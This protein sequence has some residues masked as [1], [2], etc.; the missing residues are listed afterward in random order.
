M[1]MSNFVNLLRV[2]GPVASVMMDM[3]NVIEF[4]K[5]VAPIA[6]AIA[7]TFAVIIAATTAYFSRRALKI[8]WLSNSA[9]MVSKFIGDYGSNEYRGFRRRFSQQLLAVR[10]LDEDKRAQYITEEIGIVDLPILGYFENIAYLKHRGVLDEGMVWN[11]FFWHV[12]RYYI[13]VTNPT[14][15]LKVFRQGDQ[16]TI[17]SEF[18][19]L[20][21]ELRKYDRKQRGI[22]YDEGKPEDAEVQRFLVEESRLIT[23]VEEPLSADAVQKLIQDEITKPKP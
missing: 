11:I 10:G 4:L 14:N 13:A 19:K 16:Q 20:Y 22:A 9:N 6:S 17:Y 7:A 23:K 1:D 3:S 15:L 18:E 12:E 5:I 8:N 21:N 2:I